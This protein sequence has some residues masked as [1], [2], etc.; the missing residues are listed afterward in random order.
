MSV[1]L[2]N[3]DQQKFL[4]SVCCS[5]CCTF[6]WGK[7]FAI[8]HKKGYF[9]LTEPNGTLTVCGKKQTS[10]ITKVLYKFGGLSSF[11]FTYFN[12]N[13]HQWSSNKPWE[14]GF[15]IRTKRRTYAVV[16]GQKWQESHCWLTSSFLNSDWETDKLLWGLTGWFLC[17]A[18][19]SDCKKYLLA[20]WMTEKCTAVTG[21]SL[22][23]MRIMN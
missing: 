7:A 15:Y 9:A 2:F 16:T 1:I 11:H 8:L 17:K 18:W 6:N 13:V 4:L 21:E 23:F 10:Y 3:L 12:L 20:K 14:I 22:N 5:S 19:K